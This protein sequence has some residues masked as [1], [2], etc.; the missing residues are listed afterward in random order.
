MKRVSAMTSERVKPRV[1]VGK[2]DWSPSSSKAVTSTRGAAA[3]A[4]GSVT[5]PVAAK[6]GA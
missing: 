4:C 3:I 1:K 2:A 6:T 5:A